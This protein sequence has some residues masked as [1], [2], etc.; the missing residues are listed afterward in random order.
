MASHS[1]P[2]ASRAKI[3]G[4][5]GRHRKQPQRR[6]EL[7]RRY[8][9]EGG[10]GPHLD[11]RAVGRNKRDLVVVAG[12]RR[13]RAADQNQEHDCT[14]QRPHITTAHQN[15]SWQNYHGKTI[16]AES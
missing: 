16:R 10:A 12:K 1:S 7:I 8:D 9:M 2:S 13:R 5:K 3:N 11:Q 15:E 4:G 6:I 14:D